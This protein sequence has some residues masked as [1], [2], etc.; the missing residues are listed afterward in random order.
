MA[1]EVMVARPGMVTVTPEGEAE[2]TITDIT[3]LE[4]IDDPEII[5]DPSGDSS[6]DYFYRGKEVK[7]LKFTTGDMNVLDK[8]FQGQYFSTATGNQKCVKRSDDTQKVSGNVYVYTV[9]NG[10]V[11]KLG[12]PKAQAGDGSPKRFEVEL[13]AGHDSDG[14]EGGATPTVNLS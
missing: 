14:T 4:P 12:Q 1:D 6:Y 8:L 7:G 2:V 9:T 5:E 10:C 3:D 13:R 11:F